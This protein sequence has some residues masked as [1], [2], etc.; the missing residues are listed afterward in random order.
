MRF[1]TPKRSQHSLAVAKALSK[2]A[3]QCGIVSRAH[4]PQKGR[5]FPFS[6]TFGVDGSFVNA[7][8]IIEGLK[9]LMTEERVSKIRKVAAQRQF[10][11]VP[12]IECGS[13]L[14]CGGA[15]VC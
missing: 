5:L 13:Q 4:V 1:C 15:E 3:E 14:Q 10:D 11:V 12:V 9:P 8:E 6:E 2:H 7:S